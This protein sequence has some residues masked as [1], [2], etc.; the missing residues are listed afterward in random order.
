MLLKGASIGHIS[1]KHRPVV[2]HL[3]LKSGD[4]S[5]ID[6]EANSINLCMD[7]QT[8]KRTGWMSGALRNPKLLRVIWPSIQMVTSA[9]RGAV[10][11]SISK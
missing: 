11:E 2:T 7:E 4:I 6:I 3:S 10:L 9:H 8:S 5:E 1:R